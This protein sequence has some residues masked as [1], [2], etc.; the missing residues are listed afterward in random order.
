ME[1]SLSESSVSQQNR[2]AP[3]LTGGAVPVGLPRPIDAPL[4]PLPPP[5]PLA[6]ELEAARVDLALSAALMKD[7][8]KRIDEAR[9][10]L[11]GGAVDDEATG[12]AN[13]PD[14]RGKSGG[15]SAPASSLLE[16]PAAA[17]S[18][19]RASA[20]LEARIAQLSTELVEAEAGVA[21]DA[22]R[23]REAEAGVAAEASENNAHSDSALPPAVDAYSMVV[24]AFSGGL[25]IH[26]GDGPVVSAIDGGV[27]GA[28]RPTGSAPFVSPAIAEPPQHDAEP[29]PPPAELLDLPEEMLVLVINQLP[30]G[31]CA[32]GGGLCVWWLYPLFCVG[33]VERAQDLR[34]RAHLFL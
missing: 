28:D 12:R 17:A 6:V 14:G 1:P 26:S 16:P 33:A 27:A 22:E 8:R 20:A 5:S 10:A 34:G 30:S 4:P 15:G 2:F 23:V 19:S 24:A 3:P 31:R 18:A 32:F 11:A 13:A 29:P 25:N 9:S 21:R 7:L